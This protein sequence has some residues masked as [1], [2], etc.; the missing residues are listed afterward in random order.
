MG[1]CA[2]RPVACI[3]LNT[4]NDTLAVATAA[5]KLFLQ[6]LQRAEGG[7]THLGKLFPLLQ[8]SPILCRRDLIAQCSGPEDPSCSFW[9][10]D[11]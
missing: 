2:G 10:T 6:N 4:L 1:A 8:H 3:A 7:V 5:G 9:N 11:A